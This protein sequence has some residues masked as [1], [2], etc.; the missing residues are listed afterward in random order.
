MAT[1]VRDTG[2]LGMLTGWDATELKKYELADG[3]P[4][5]AVASQMQTAAGF[6]ANEL[7]GDPIWASLV[8]YT[9]ML[10]LEYRVG[11]SNGASRY[12]EY[13]TPDPKRAQTEGHMLPLMPWDRGLGWTW[14]Y[15]ESARMPQI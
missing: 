4:F 14:R 11:V 7:Y 12:T 13:G 10:E 5:S 15:L 9:D 3:T 6:V 1:G 8:S 2:S